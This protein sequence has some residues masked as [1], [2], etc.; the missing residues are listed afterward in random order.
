MEFSRAEYWKTLG[1]VDSLNLFQSIF[2]T[3]ELNR[4]L[5]HYR[6]IL[7]QLSYHGS[8]YPYNITVILKAKCIFHTRINWEYKFL[9]NGNINKLVYLFIGMHY[10]HDLPR[11]Y[12]YVVK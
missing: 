12:S 1:L 6:Q 2:L 11:V 8:P 3:L 9:K 5:L 4:G 10:Y 7:Y